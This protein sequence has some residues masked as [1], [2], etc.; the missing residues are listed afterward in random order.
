MRKTAIFVT[1]FNF[2]MMNKKE[3]E[4]KR[5]MENVIHCCDEQ[6]SCETI[7]GK[8]RRENI[9]MIR[10]LF[11]SQMISAG[12]TITTIAK[13]L[14]RTPQAIRHMAETAYQFNKTSRAYRIAE[15]EANER[16]KELLY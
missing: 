8:C 7:V 16:N 1:E 3:E 5:I 9:Q 2:L 13:T 4:I 10:T 15:R 6:C 11:V 14:K 12:Y